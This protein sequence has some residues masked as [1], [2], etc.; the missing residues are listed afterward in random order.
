M[1]FELSSEQKL[2][3]DTAR[4]FAKNELLPGVIERDEN[5]EFPKSQIEKMAEMGFFRHDGKSQI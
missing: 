2:I 1:N 4:N 5:K 3:R